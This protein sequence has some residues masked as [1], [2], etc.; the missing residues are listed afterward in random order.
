MAGFDRERLHIRAAGTTFL[1]ALIIEQPIP[2]EP[3]VMMIMDVRSKYS[4]GLGIYRLIDANTVDRSDQNS[5][6]SFFAH[7]CQSIGDNRLR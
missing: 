5:I 3:P 2:D 1:I 6:G 7:R 4:E